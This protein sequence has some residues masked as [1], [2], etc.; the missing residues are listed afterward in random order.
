MMGNDRLPLDHNLI[1]G[2]CIV[3]YKLRSIDPRL[4]LQRYLLGDRQDSRVN[5]FD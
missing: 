5:L 2:I 1:T 4:M 3:Q